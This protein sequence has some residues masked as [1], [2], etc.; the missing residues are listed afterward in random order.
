VTAARADRVPSRSRSLLGP[1]KGD[2]RVDGKD[3][4][5]AC[6]MLARDYQVT[7]G[8]IGKS[9]ADLPCRFASSRGVS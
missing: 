5:F 8:A 3:D 4:I 1:D 9:R 6:G 2:K 7:T